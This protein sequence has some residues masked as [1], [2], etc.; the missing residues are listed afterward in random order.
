MISS[1]PPESAGREKKR[2]PEVQ[3][4]EVKAPEVRTTDVTTK[5]APTTANAAVASQ[6]PAVAVPA[7]TPNKKATGL[8]FRRFFSKPGVS[9]YDEVEWEL[10]TAAITDSQ[11]GIIF[12]QKDVEVP[13]DWSMT[14][15]N[16]VAS[17]YLHG[18]LDTPERESG[19]R[20]L[21]TRVAETIRDWGIAGGYF[22]SSHDAEVFHDELTLMLL[23]QRVAFNSPVWFN[24]GCDRLE[25]KSSGQNWHWDP[26]T[27]GVRYSATGYKN[28]Q[29]SACFINSVEDSLE[30]ILT[31][32][33][34]EGMLF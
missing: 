20:A 21:V 15:T 29:C 30:S 27:G 23:T 9:P 2:M 3:T 17:K 16:I 34:T 7:V 12:E 10:R 6:G 28:P 19:V 18:P 22:A 14:A 24:V 4:T 31:L 26:S 1:G 5:A 13:K 33:K 25:P 8:S 32:A 11:G